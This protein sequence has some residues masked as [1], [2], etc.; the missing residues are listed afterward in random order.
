MI[1]KDNRIISMGYN[2]TPS[3]WDNNCEEELFCYDERETYFEREEWTFDSKRKGFTQLKTKPEIIHAEM[4]ALFK[5]ARSHE[6]GEGAVMFCTH[7]PCIECA[8]GIYGSGINHYYYLSDY[9][10][11]L[12]LLFLKRSGVL[13]DKVEK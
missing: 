6:S 7:S 9:R 11:D 12:G 10:D 4:N 13:V 3:G 2:G 8:K 1:V 5:L